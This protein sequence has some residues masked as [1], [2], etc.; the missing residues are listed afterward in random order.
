MSKKKVRSYWLK[1][2]KQT[3]TIIIFLVSLTCTASDSTQSKILTLGLP[4]NLTKEYG[5]LNFGVESFQRTDEAATG[6]NFTIHGTSPHGTTNLAY[7]L[8]K[9][10]DGRPEVWTAETQDG[11]AFSNSR[12]V[13]EIPTADTPT[14][15]IAASVALHDNTILLLQSAYGN[16]PRK[17]HRFFAFTGMTDGT[18]WKRMTDSPVYKGQDA[19]KIVWN[20]E[21]KAFVNYHISYQPFIKRNPDNLLIVRRVLHIRTSKDGLVWTPGQSF[22]A[23][24]PYLPTEMLITPDSLDCPD[25]E[26]Y[27]FS[28]FRFGDY[29]AGIMVDYAAQPKIIPNRKPWPHGPFLD[30][31]WWV[32]KDGFKWERPYR[33]NS[34]LEKIPLKFAYN[35]SDPIIYG[36]ELR[37]VSEGSVFKQRRQRLFYTYSRSHS[38]IMT[39]ALEL[40]DKPINLELSFESIR[41]G[42][43]NPLVQGY[44]MAELVD[45]SGNVIKGFERN[46]CVNTP[47]ESTRVTLRWGN[48]N[49][50]DI[51][52]N[53]RVSIRFIFRDCRL[54]SVSY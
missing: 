3:V 47:D 53:R 19:L 37:W 45:E 34:G 12:K 13:F 16:P 27:K 9:S 36:D 32:S 26:F 51:T 44:V 54:Y 14:R 33:E 17:G 23:D 43:S 5:K 38:E 21:K 25:K 42:E 1:G 30:F 22:G 49:L 10:A 6:L 4:W 41:R 39:T 2:K 48:K 8:S 40:T 15:W 20:E 31:E 50:P 28:V 18:G 35:L 46:N 24:G 29:W 7:G 52:K 11:N